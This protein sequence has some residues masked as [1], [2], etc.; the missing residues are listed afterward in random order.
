LIAS[1]ASSVSRTILPGLGIFSLTAP[2]DLGN[3]TNATRIPPTA[4]AM[5]MLIAAEKQTL[6]LRNV[7][8]FP[9]IHLV[10]GVIIQIPIYVLV[11]ASFTGKRVS[12]THSEIVAITISWVCHI[13]DTIAV[14]ISKDC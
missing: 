7:P 5:V 2:G 8:A 14:P 3:R 10:N 13:P 12:A 9:T 1:L 4:K 6:T 11:V